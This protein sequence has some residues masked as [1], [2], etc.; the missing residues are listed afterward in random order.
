LERG[1]TL[2]GLQVVVFKA[3][4]FIYDAGS[5]VQIAGRVGRKTSNPFGEVIFLVNEKTKE[6]NNTIKDIERANEY[7]QNL[8]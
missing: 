8:F 3:D 2:E 5:L 7:L 6:T 1:V 4:H